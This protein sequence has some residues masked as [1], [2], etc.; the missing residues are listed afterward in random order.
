MTIHGGVELFPMDKNQDEKITAT[1]HNTNWRP[2]EII[3]DRLVVLQKKLQILHRQIASRQEIGARGIKD[4]EERICELG[5]EIY[6]IDELPSSPD[7]PRGETKARLASEKA[8]A[9]KELFAEKLGLWRDLYALQT[10][11]MLIQNECMRIAKRRSFL[12]EGRRDV[13]NPQTPVRR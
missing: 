1:G 7:S 10:D 2:E 9:E 11:A 5:S 4:L 6:S 3:D 12:Y 8:R 13:Q